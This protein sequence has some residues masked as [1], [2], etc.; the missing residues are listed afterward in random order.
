MLGDDALSGLPT[1]SPERALYISE[2]HCPSLMKRIDTYI[3]L[4]GRNMIM[5]SPCFKVIRFR[6]DFGYGVP[7]LGIG[8]ESPQRGTSEDL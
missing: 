4:K 5:I 7:A 8:A 3:A 6:G 1:D 2:G